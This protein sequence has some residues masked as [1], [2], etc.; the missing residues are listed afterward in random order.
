[1]S[2]NISRIG[3]KI[4]SFKTAPEFDG[5]SKVV[6]VVSE[7][8]EYSAGTDTGRTLTIQNPWGTQAMADRILTKVLG[9]QY[10]PYTA[11]GAMIDPSVELGDGVVVNRAYG[12]IYQRKITFGRDYRADISA[13]GEEE[14][15]HEFP[16]VP[17]EERKITR[18][19]NSLT[20]ELKIQSGLI[21]AKV[22]R[23]GGDGTSFGWVLDDSSWTI[24]A[25]KGGVMFNV[26]K[27]TAEGLEVW[28]KI[29][30]ESGA[31]G[32]FLLSDNALS[33]NG[34]TFGGTNSRGIYIGPSG[35]QLGPY[36]QVDAYGNLTASSGKF[37]G[38]VYAGN[39]QYGSTAGYFSGSGISGGSIYGNR[40]VSNTVTTAYTSPGI[41]TSLG[42][43]NF[44]NDVFG[45]NDTASYVKTKALIVNGTQFTK[46]TISF[47]DYYGNTRTYYVLA[48]AEE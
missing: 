40:L 33:T 30:A 34:Q 27:A 7:D 43:A 46:K 47:V 5:Y 31:I 36:F 2:D 48:V 24:Q 44:A 13:P 1:M 14:I 9:F 8:L 39:I 10:Q 11:T 29:Y 6:I 28:G 3:K 4:R 12:G 23:T 22:S 41:N 32:G 42:Y 20:S 38:N 18:Q 37:T 15:E 17:K 45:G 35:I 19:L 16:Y 21:E 26:L 25:D